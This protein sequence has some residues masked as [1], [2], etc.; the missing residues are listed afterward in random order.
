MSDKT[1]KETEYYLYNHKNLNEL[2]DITDTKIEA[3]N[4]DVSLKAIS[5][6][7]KSGSTNKFNSDVENEVIRREEKNEALI[8][9]LKK[10]KLKRNF[11]AKIVDNFLNTLDAEQK[12]IIELRY[13]AKPKQSWTQ[14][15][16]ETNRSVAQC[17]RERSMLVEKLAKMINS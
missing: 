1:F 11:I 15:S 7:E 12:K 8:E 17:I 5:Y 3:L 4:N 2:N 16:L 6:E 9:A 14:I 13:F 10:E